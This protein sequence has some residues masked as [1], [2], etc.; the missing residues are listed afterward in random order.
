VLQWR[1]AWWTDRTALVALVLLCVALKGILLAREPILA[2]DGIH[3]IKFAHD[4]SSSDDEL[5][6]RYAT[7]LSFATVTKAEVLKKH[8]Y[9]PGYPLAIAGLAK[10]WQVYLPGDLSP[11]QWQWC[12]HAAASLAGV[13]L[14][15]PLFGL[16]RCFLP[17][18]SAWAATALFLILPATVQITTDSLAES[19][20][21]LFMFSGLWCLVQAVREPKP[22]WFALAGL[23]AGC[24]YLVRLEALLLP[25]AGMLIL[26]TQRWWC[27]TNMPWKAAL[28]GA[29][30]LGGCFVVVASPYM[31]LIGKF[32]NRPSMNQLVPLAEL[33]PAPSWQGPLMCLASRQQDGVNGQRVDAVKLWDAVKLVVTAHGKAGHYFLWPLAAIGAVMLWRARRTDPAV[34]LWGCVTIVHVAMLLRLAYSAGYTSERHTLLLVSIAS[35]PGVVGINHVIRRYLSRIGPIHFLIALVV[36]GLC[37]PRALQPLH[38][39][40]EGHRQAGIWLSTRLSFLDT[41]TDPYQWVSFYA[42]ELTKRTGAR[43]PQ[44]WDGDDFY[45]STEELKQRFGDEIRGQYT[46]P[47]RRALGVVDPRDNDLNRFRDWKQAGVTGPGSVVIWSWPC[48]ER[49]KLVIRQAAPAGANTVAR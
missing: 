7:G 5:S 40:Q 43:I 26:I 21:L 38:A 18:S 42:G 6:M 28:K 14:V 1:E 45:S 3:Y 19:W 47:P 41:L 22:R 29:L 11:E 4:L 37:L 10:L 17:T 44:I 46:F 20:L 34:G 2:R 36:V 15:I 9:H 25:A 35:I 23:C 39:G 27:G 49:P 13:L 33:L 12:A 16:A 32:S 31:V 48:A 8:P 30:V 24:G